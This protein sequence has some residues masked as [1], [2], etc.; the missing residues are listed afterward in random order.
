MQKHDIWPPTEL[1]RQSG[2]P[3]PMHRTDGKPL[4]PDK[5]LSDRAY[6]RAWHR[7]QIAKQKS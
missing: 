6:I 4:E 2:L 7:R 3:D 1:R 5:R